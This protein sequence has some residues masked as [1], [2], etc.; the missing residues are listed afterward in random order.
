MTTRSPLGPPPNTPRPERNYAHEMRRKI[1]ELAIGTY[2]PAMVAHQI[3]RW[4]KE[5]DP[6]LLDG[7]L[8]AQA[9]AFVRGAINERDRSVRAS[10]RHGAAARSF[11]RDAEA[12]ESGDSLRLHGWLK[13]AFSLSNGTRMPLAEMTNVELYDVATTFRV[14]SEG[15]AMTAA[16]LDAVAR[17][18]GQGKVSDHFDDETL[19]TM[20]KTLVGS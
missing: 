3:V 20:W 14:R 10:A 9:E 13:V 12:A 4:A 8:N 7:W 16:F 2:I 6:D 11:R 18:I 19:G 5:N 17:R 15:N 1:D